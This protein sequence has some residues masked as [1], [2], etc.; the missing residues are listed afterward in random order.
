ML[1][2]FYVVFFVGTIWLG[3]VYNHYLKHGII[4]NL[5]LALSLFCVINFMICLWEISLFFYID[6]IKSRYEAMKKKLP[7]GSIGTI[8]LLK[9]ASLASAVTLEYWS[10]IWSTYSLFDPSYSD[11]KSFG[12]NIDIGNGFSTLIPTILFGNN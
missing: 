11:T 10:D 1:S 5:Q 9:P 3:L 7:K 2:I 4:N 8:F 6:R 12:W